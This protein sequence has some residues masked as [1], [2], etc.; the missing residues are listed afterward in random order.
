PNSDVFGISRR[1]PD[2]QRQRLKDVLKKLRP[3]GHGMIA[4]TAAEHA[5]A[6]ELEADLTRLT[7]EWE[8]IAKS[9]KK[10]KAP[11][12][13]YEEPELTVRVVRD[14]FTDEEFKELVT[15]SDDLFRTI[16]DYLQRVAPDLVQKLRRH[17]GKLSVM[18]AYHVVE[19]IHKA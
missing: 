15:D 7:A 8:A 4:R 1:L 11:R 9:A 16:V 6:E 12:V 17:D 2:K 14:L 19:Q 10:G 13:L 18:E 5:G 3:P